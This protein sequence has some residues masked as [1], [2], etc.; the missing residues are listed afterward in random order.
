MKI[1][2]LIRLAAIPMLFTISLTAKAQWVVVDPTN[3]IQNTIT[4]IQAVMTEINTAASYAEHVKTTIELAKSTA[5]MD[6]LGSLAGL[7][8]E[9]DL[10]RNLVE[11]GQRMD[12]LMN[13]SLQLTKN[14]QAQFGASDVSWETFMHNRSANEQDQA[15]TLAQQYGYINR[16]LQDTADRRKQLLNSLQSATGQTSATQAVGAQID[17]LIG[18]QQQMINELSRQKK[19]ESDKIKQEQAQQDAYNLYNKQ[20][21]KRLEESSARFNKGGYPD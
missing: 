8:Q 4:S 16:S 11:N 10:Y 9:Y 7:S 2:N 12:N 18:Q 17:V 3:L 20:Y 15:D 21:Q 6:G 5:S 19:A 13:Q 14:I 1:K